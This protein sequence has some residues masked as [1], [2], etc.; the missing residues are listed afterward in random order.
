MKKISFATQ[1]VKTIP[2]PEYQKILA[3]MSNTKDSSFLVLM[4][5]N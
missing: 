2:V 4:R 1:L 5:Q 3:D